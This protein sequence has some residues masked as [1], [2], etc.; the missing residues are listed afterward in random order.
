MHV[1]KRLLISGVILVLLGKGLWIGM[2]APD[3]DR[4]SFNDYVSLVMGLIEDLENDDLKSV[5]GPS[6]FTSKY[7]EARID[8]DQI[9]NKLIV[10]IGVESAACE[11]TLYSDLLEL[12]DCAYLIVFEALRRHQGNEVL[13]KNFE[14]VRQYVED[15]GYFP[16][17]DDA[18]MNQNRAGSDRFEILVDNSYRMA[19]INVAC[20]SD[21]LFLRSRGWVGS[22]T[23]EQC[24]HFETEKKPTASEYVI[25]KLCRPIN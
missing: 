17:E 22:D 20:F 12:E 11:A 9:H 3:K 18:C 7:R 14:Y 16:F 5:P 25:R 19:W 23:F 13:V 1:A 21:R 6:S 2:A 8:L 24:L 10:E 15:V 4:W